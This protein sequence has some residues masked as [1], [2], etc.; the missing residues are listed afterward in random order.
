[1]ESHCIII[2][3]NNTF[4]CPGIQNNLIAKIGK[5]TRGSVINKLGVNIP[6][7]TRYKI[8]NMYVVTGIL[9][10]PNLNFFDCLWFELKIVQIPLLFA[11]NQIVF[12]LEGA[13][14]CPSFL[15]NFCFL[16]FD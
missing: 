5:K 13:P 9:N 1:M 16:Q 6:V 2:P 7:R 10:S 8:N 4:K 3:Q 14:P 15:I 12:L 11:E